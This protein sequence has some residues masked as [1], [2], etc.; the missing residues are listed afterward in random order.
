MSLQWEREA[1]EQQELQRPVLLM[2]EVPVTPAVLWFSLLPF[3]TPRVLF[4]V[5]DCCWFPRAL[6][7][8][9]W[10]KWVS[11]KVFVI[12]WRDS[13][14]SAGQGAESQ[15]ERLDIHPTCSACNMK[16]GRSPKALGYFWL[17]FAAH[18]LCALH[19][20]YRSQ[21]S[22]GTYLLSCQEHP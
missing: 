13:G 21:A 5:Q 14:L 10:T 20:S 22:L 7:P 18:S 9:C 19:I 8:P 17:L 3:I 12:Q 15:W 6:F 1:Q 11:S 4:S 16:R 2:G